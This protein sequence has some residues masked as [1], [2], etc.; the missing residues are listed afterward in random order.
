MRTQNQVWINLWKLWIGTAVLGVLRARVTA[1]RNV[2][3]ARL[4]R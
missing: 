3:E 4:V 2:A 1:A